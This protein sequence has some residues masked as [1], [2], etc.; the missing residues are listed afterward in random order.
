ML[1]LL[2][3]EFLLSWLQCVIEKSWG[4]ICQLGRRSACRR[5]G[6]IWYP[7]GSD[8]T[9][10]VSAWRLWYSRIWLYH[11]SAVTLLLFS[12]AFQQHHHHWLIGKWITTCCES[13][14]SGVS[15]A[16]KHETFLD[17]LDHSDH[18]CSVGLLFHEAWTAAKT[19]SIFTSF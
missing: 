14:R 16:R 18:G 5:R 1:E 12:V 15:L 10:E 6:M 4:K 11:P 2:H 8:W 17:P 7:V 19:G 9:A 13:E 3:I